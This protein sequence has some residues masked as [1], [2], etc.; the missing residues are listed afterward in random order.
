[1]R[2]IKILV[3]LIAL[4]MPMF[5]LCFAAEVSQGKC[6]MYDPEAKV[7]VIEEYDTNFS[8]EHPYGKSTGIKNTYRIDKAKIGIKPEKGDILRIAY[9]IKNNERHA[10]K[11]MNVSKQDL[12]KK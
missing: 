4:F 8:H 3:M 1:M 5:G 11:V 7:I 9:D 6:I 2:K 12:R 10:I